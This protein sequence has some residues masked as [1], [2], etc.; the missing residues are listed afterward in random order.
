[1]GNWK[2]FGVLLLVLGLAACG[3]DSS[4]S[5]GADDGAADDRAGDGDG[6]VADSGDGDGDSGDGD[7]DVADSGDGDGGDGDGDSGDA[8]M[9]CSP[10][11]GTEAV[12]MAYL[13]SWNERDPDKRLCFLQQA[14]TGSTTYIDPTA[15]T[16]GPDELDEVIA[17]FFTMFPDGE[18][19]LT[20]EL[21]LRDSDGRFSWEVISGGA[22][23][24]SGMDYIEL[25]DNGRLRSIRGYW[26]EPMDAVDSALA[27]YVSAWNGT[28]EPPME[29]LAQAVTED[30]RFTDDAQDLSGPAALAEHIEALQS[31]TTL[32]SVTVTGAQSYSTHARIVLELEDDSGVTE[33]R[34]YLLLDDDGLITRVGRF[35]GPIAPL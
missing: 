4:A 3:D 12:L 16:T 21:E 14:F 8:A 25:D 28:A 18:L 31:V 34:D 26:G 6:D 2:L 10:P 1:M 22:S 9:W 24:I 11:D 30:V 32:F 29:D 35:E 23:V 13:E 27:D 15:N 33:Y 5:N 19:P 20:S 17:G 7:G